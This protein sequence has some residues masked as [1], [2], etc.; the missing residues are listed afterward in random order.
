MRQWDIRLP[1]SYLMGPCV[2]VLAVC[3]GCG[4]A[5][6][7]SNQ[8][9]STNQPPSSSPR[10]STKTPSTGGTQTLASGNTRPNGTSVPSGLPKPRGKGGQRPSDDFPPGTSNDPPNSPGTGNRLGNSGFWGTTDVAQTIALPDPLDERKLEAAGL[11]TLSGKHLTIVTDLPSS[12]EID[13]LCDVFDAAY[14]QWCEYFGVSEKMPEGAGMDVWHCRAY[15]M[16]DKAKFLATGLLPE[17]LE[18]IPNGYSKNYEFW[19]FDQPTDYYRRHLMLHEGTHSFMHTRLPGT[20]PAWYTEGIAELMGTHKWT[21]DSLKINYFPQNNEEV[22]DWG[23]IKLVS[24]ACRQNQGLFFDQVLQLDTAIPAKPNG[25]FTNQAYAWG[26]AVCAFLDG[27]PRYQQR[28]RE[29]V[30]GLMKDAAFPITF[31]TLYAAD[32]DDLEEEWQLF[33]TNLDYGYDLQRNAVE[34]K[35]GDSVGET[36]RTVTIAADRGWQSTGVELLLG[37]TYEIKASGR[38]ELGQDPVPWVSEPNGVTI[39]YYNGKP[40]GM[41]IG[42]IHVDVRGMHTATSFLRGGEVGLGTTVT[43]E[44]TGTLYLKVNDAPDSLADNTGTV[45]VSIRRVPTPE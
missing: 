19:L 11:R 36:P 16:K 30:P 18:S 21:G 24:E 13:G 45:E 22:P 29:K 31:K 37:T 25:Y 44:V 1:Y 43:P 39:R 17:S 12:P 28:F 2:L 38:Y 8:A 14:P 26:W 42:A 5:E 34:F 32:W 23:R 10:T 6:T 27:H 15:L 33:A 3:L 9:A 4:S 20:S 41:L 35:I 40:L 7:P